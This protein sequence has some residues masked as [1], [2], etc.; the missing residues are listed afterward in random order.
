MNEFGKNLKKIRNQA[1]YTQDQMAEK[2]MI[3]ST[4]YKNYEQG[5]CY[6]PIEKIISLCNILNVSAD[7]LLR[8]EDRIFQ[9]YA[10]SAFFQELCKMSDEESKAIFYAFEKLIDYKKTYS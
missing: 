2:L 5:V 8:N 1:G 4:Q 7:Y 10:T 6:P 9:D 3:S